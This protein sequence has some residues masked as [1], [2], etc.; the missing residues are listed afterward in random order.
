MFCRA[1]SITGPV[2]RF[3]DPF[4]GE[5]TQLQVALSNKYSG[6]VSGMIASLR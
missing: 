4:A 1:G 5:K 6:D 2:N 3:D